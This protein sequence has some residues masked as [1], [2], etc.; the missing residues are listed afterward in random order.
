MEWKNLVSFGLAG[1]L[2]FG[3]VGCKDKNN[4]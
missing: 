2:A 3:V 4:L 1:A